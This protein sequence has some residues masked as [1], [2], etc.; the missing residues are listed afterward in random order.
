[1]RHGDSVT[2]P[3]YYYYYV[4]GTTLNS[5]VVVQGMTVKLART[6]E[7]VQ[8][9]GCVTVTVSPNQIIIIIIIIIIIDL[10]L[11]NDV[12]AIFDV[13]VT[14]PFSTSD[15]DSVEFKLC[16]PSSVQNYNSRTNYNFKFARWD[17][18]Y[19]DLNSVNW[20]DL[21][22]CSIDQ[23]WLRFMLFL[24]NML[25]KPVLQLKNVNS[26]KN[27]PYPYHI[28][29]LL[30]LKTLRWRILKLSRNEANK[31]AY[32]DVAAQCRGAIFNLIRTREELIMDGENLGRFYKYANKKLAS[33]NGIGHNKKWRLICCRPGHSSYFI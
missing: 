19:S 7:F 8:F 20:D 12:F 25:D 1:M 3:D 18:M 33:K 2:E 30:R 24:L 11:S 9:V 10:V 31:T 16:T 5:S 27:K 21:F 23:C 17:D 26:A 28:R 32:L 4:L 29:K 6:F 15:H 13:N 22:N 14:Q